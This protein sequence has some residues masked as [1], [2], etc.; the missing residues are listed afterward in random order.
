MVEELVSLSQDCLSNLCT[1]VKLAQIREN[2]TEADLKHEERHY[3]GETA[4][5]VSILTVV[6]T[7]SKKLGFKVVVIYLSSSVGSRLQINKY[8]ML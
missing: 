6:T 8:A 4:L 2:V 5:L 7:M 3:W 1:F